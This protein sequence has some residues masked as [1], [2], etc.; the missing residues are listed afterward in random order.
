M[1]QKNTELQCRGYKIGVCRW[2]FWGLIAT[3]QGVVAVL[4]GGNSRSFTPKFSTICPDNYPIFGVTS[5]KSVIFRRL[6]IRTLSCDI[7]ELGLPRS[8]KPRFFE[9]TKITFVTFLTKN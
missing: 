8:K 6:D 4:L 1:E 9:G 3:P 5:P 7:R 2:V